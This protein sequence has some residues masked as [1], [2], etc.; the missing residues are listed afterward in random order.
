[1]WR[2]DETRDNKFVFIGRDLD[3]PRLRDA[4]LDCLH[5]P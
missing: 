5:Q 1:V 4:F 3:M 2:A